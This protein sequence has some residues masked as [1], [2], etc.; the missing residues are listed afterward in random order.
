MKEGINMTKA[1]IE[2]IL[3]LFPDDAEV[4]AEFTFVDK[5]NV[6]YSCYIEGINLDETPDKGL[7]ATLRLFEK[8][9]K[10]AA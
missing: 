2:Q 1:T 6:T 5:Y 4:E 3:N 8:K 10:D 9:E 7:T